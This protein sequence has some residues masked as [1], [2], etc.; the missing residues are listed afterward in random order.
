VNDPL[1]ELALQTRLKG[2]KS[3]LIRLTAVFLQHCAGQLDDI[4]QALTRS[5][6]QALCHSAHTFKGTVLSFE[7]RPS[8]AL[9]LALEERGRE[10]Q[11]AGAQE[12]LEQLR[13]EAERLRL[14]LE[15]LVADPQAWPE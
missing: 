1:D 7:A 3:R 11:L 12:V 9:A 5:D 13:V 2:K 6:S 10:G 8:A 15:Q 4:H 14:R